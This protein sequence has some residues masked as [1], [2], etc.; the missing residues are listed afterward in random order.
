MTDFYQEL[1]LIQ[2]DSLQKI[3][4]DL[5]QLEQ[6]WRKREVNRPEVATEKLAMINQAKKTF[7]SY[8]S[9]MAYDQE[10]IDAAQKKPVEDP[11][12]ENDEKFKQ[13]YDTAM[14]YYNQKRYDLAKTAMENAIKYLNSAN[15]NQETYL[16]IAN[17][18]VVC[19]EYQTALKYV[20]EAILLNDQ[21][22]KAYLVQG[23]IYLEMAN[24]KNDPQHVDNS[25]YAKQSCEKAIEL[26]KDGVDNYTFGW[27]SSLLAKILLED[28]ANNQNYYI[29]NPDTPLELQIKELVNNSLKYA[30]PLGDAAR[31]DNALKA[32]ETA[33]ER[34]AQFRANVQCVTESN[35]QPTSPQDISQTG[36][37]RRSASYDN[38]PS[39]TATPVIET[40]N[41]PNTSVVNTGETNVSNT[42][43]SDKLPPE[44]KPY[45]K[46]Q[47]DPNKTKYALISAG[48]ALV[49][50]LIFGFSFFGLLVSAFLGFVAFKLLLKYA[51]NLRNNFSGQQNNNANKSKVE[52][53]NSNTP[54]KTPNSST[55]IV[56]EG[57]SYVSKQINPTASSKAIAPSTKNAPEV[58]FTKYE[59]VFSD[60]IYQFDY[61]EDILAPFFALCKQ[62]SLFLA[63]EPNIQV[64]EGGNMCTCSYKLQIGGKGNVYLWRDSRNGA[65]SVEIPTNVTTVEDNV[66]TLLYDFL[67]HIYTINGGSAGVSAK[68]NGEKWDRLTPARRSY[69]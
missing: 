26:S 58:A 15:V 52:I 24:D 43:Q 66:A 18:Y 3:Q 57:D 62:Y 1:G 39:T 38:N 55:F 67:Q 34:N 69:M 54:V 21:T 4:D 30:D 46:K 68:K 5:I 53:E 59:V 63:E 47:D 41:V 2:N 45:V 6:T 50:W 22:P 8:M 19:N 48:V 33:R 17:L 60:L 12:T 65:A 40:T 64:F 61:E 20:N 35:S 25:K 23:F 49:F 7:S 28:I 36:R 11:D 29:D 27:A 10:L 51:S 32:L 42:T 13:Y 31:I 56:K 16:N 37:R 14:S 44:F 9:K